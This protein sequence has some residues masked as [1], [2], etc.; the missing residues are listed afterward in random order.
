MYT[1]N[2][3]PVTILNVP[4]ANANATPIATVIRSPVWLIV[5]AETSS[6]FMATAISEG[7][8]IVVEK[9]IKAEKI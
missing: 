2:E 7:S 6:A 3:V 8:A 4:S 1:N 5:P 9:P